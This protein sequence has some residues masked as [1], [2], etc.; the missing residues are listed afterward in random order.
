[1]SKNSRIL[2]I[3][4]RL[5]QGRIINK[6]E[7]A[8]RYCVDARS[9]QRD[10]DDIRAFLEEQRASGTGNGLRV[11]YD[12][13]QKGY[14]MT[15]EEEVFL[16][17]SEILAVS[18]I[19]LE[20]RAFTKKEM[21]SILGKMVERCVPLK[22]MK[23]VS[24]LLANEQYHYVELTDKS[25]VQDMLWELGTAIKNR[26]LIK[27]TYH[28][29]AEASDMIKRTLR[30]LAVLFSEYYFYLIADIVTVDNNT[31]EI[32]GKYEYPAVFRID[33]IR[34]CKITDRKFTI[35][36]ASRFEEGEFRKRVQFMYPGRLM[37]VQF[38]YSGKS[39]SSIL[40]RLPTARILSKDETG[41]LIE[42]ETYGTGIV[43]WLLSQGEY[44]EVLKPEELRMEMI[45]K[46]QRMEENYMQ[47]Q[48][49]IS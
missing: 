12:R 46:L 16:N 2:D 6:A 31:G 27:I 45:E 38:R 5:S 4:A 8:R 15:G 42:A 40:D 24:E 48:T 14:R 44:I 35:P 43:M 34:T 41:Y 17:N 37:R 28:K 30:P 10:I 11:E 20:S 36:Y 39:P 22:N 25:C 33:R 29:Q 23:L 21:E 26:N 13:S 18:K 49:E 9:I 19:L 7:E 32:H 47:P 3:Y 1:M